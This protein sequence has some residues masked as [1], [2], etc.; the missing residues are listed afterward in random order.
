MQRGA[1]P[2]APRPAPPWPQRHGRVALLLAGIPV[3]L[4]GKKPEAQALEGDTLGR[5]L[6]RRRRELGLRR[7]D[8]ALLLSCDEKSLMW[9]ERDMR[10]P[11][12]SFYPAIIRFLEREPWPEPATLAEQL[13]AERRRR[14]LSIEDAAKVVGVDEGT[15]G[16]WECG[17][18]EPQRRSVLFIERFL[19]RTL[20][21]PSVVVA[22]ELIA[23]IRT[24]RSRGR[25][26][27]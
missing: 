10:E 7:V 14:G 6:R 19:N 4:R 3:R 8:V 23:R 1:F 12:V 11:V 21:A 25:A 2:Q 5:Q 16:Q 17:A 18:W 26:I 9:W 20:A 22:V 15:Y 24:S 27:G 13:K